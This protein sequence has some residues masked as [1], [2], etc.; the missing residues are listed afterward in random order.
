MTMILK[1][2]VAGTVA[3]DRDTANSCCGDT[4]VQSRRGLYPEF[5]HRRGASNNRA[6]STLQPQAVYQDMTQSKLRS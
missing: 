3:V 2:R 1:L 5:G 4:A 6:S